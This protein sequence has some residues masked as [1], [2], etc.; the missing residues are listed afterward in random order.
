[1]RLALVIFCFSY[2][3]QTAQAEQDEQIGTLLHIARRSYELGHFSHA[4]TFCEAVIFLDGNHKPAQDLL[5]RTK[6]ASRDEMRRVRTV[7]HPVENLNSIKSRQLDRIRR[8]LESEPAPY[9]PRYLQ[10]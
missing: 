9:E 5:R 7:L 2:L 8:A 10:R 1:M 3:T 4:K 6:I